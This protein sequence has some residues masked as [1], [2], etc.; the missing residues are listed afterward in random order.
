M[1]YRIGEMAEFF[2][3]T[4]EGVRFMERQGVIHSV[5]DENNGYRYFPRD[6]ITRLK[7]IR[8][9]QGLGFSLDEARQMVCETSR[10]DI[11]DKIDTKM[12]EL[13][14]KEAQIRRMKNLLRTQREAVRHLM[15]EEGAR[16]WLGTR[17]EMIFFPRVPDEASG[18]TPAEREQIAKARAMEKEWIRAA[19]PCTL[20]AMHYGRNADAPRVMG[21]IV[22]AEAAREAALPIGQGMVRLKECPCVCGVVEAMVGTPPDIEP[23]L[24]FGREHGLRI[25]GDVYGVLWVTYAD[26][27]G[28]RYGIHE[29]YIPVEAEEGE[30]E[31][32]RQGCEG[33]KG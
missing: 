28:M 11:A 9:Y 22:R 12:R 3:M 15:E 19:P 29:M 7:Q 17:P 25:C 2:G 31:E 20:G 14:E 26:E 13:E 30:E 8:R 1:R 18:S 32:N 10:E 4:K 27:A 21:S 5:R 6:E 24:A 16:I 23:L 33:K